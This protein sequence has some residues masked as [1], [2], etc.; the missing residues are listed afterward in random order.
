LSQDDDGEIERS[1]VSLSFGVGGLIGERRSYQKRK[2]R[3][4][5]S[6]RRKT[7]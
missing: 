1:A 5:R 2:R 4:R 6:K 3:R 7:R